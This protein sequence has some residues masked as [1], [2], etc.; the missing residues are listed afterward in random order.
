MAA[1][2]WILALLAALTILAVNVAAV[3]VAWRALF[4]DRARGRRRCPRCWHDLSRTPGLTCSECGFQARHERQLARTRRRWGIAAASIGICVCLAGWLHWEFSSTRWISLVP[5]S[6]LTA[7]LPINDANGTLHRELTRRAARDQLTDRQWLSLLQRCRKGDPWT[8]PTSDA[9]IDKYGRLLSIAQGQIFNSGEEEWI[10]GAEEILLSVPP[11]VDLISRVWW[12]SGEP[13][14][15]DLR[16]RDW[17]PPRTACRVRI[18]PELEQA[19]PLTVYRGARRGPTYSFE[20]PELGPDRTELTFAVDVQRRP[21]KGE[22]EATTVD[23]D[24]EQV[25][26]QTFTVRPPP[27]PSPEALPAPFDDPSL[28]D[29]I[30][31]TFAQGVVRWD[32]GSRPVRFYFTPQQTYQA[33]FNGVA[34]GVHV[35]L[36]RN[37]EV[38]R[39]LDIWWLAGQSEADR[40]VGWDSGRESDHLLHELKEG[41]DWSLRVTGDPLLARRAGPVD[42]YWT[43]EV[44]VPVRVNELEGSAPAPA[45]WTG[46]ADQS[47]SEAAR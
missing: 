12:Q 21:D 40:G 8:A 25:Y 36:V 26:R 3:Y 11:R 29:A 22:D 7:L 6:A 46:P 23:P 13:P 5:T 43:G 15:F 19:T 16:L 39:R 30:E 27:G 41:A 28:A 33:A 17:W 38:A 24:W 37:G 47:K 20:I 45:W 44:I 9:W 32:S 1:P 4:A 35:D 18:A 14:R 31:A 42:R 34:V 10:E 2:T